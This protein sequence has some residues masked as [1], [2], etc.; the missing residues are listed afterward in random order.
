MVSFPQTALP[1]LI[2]AEVVPSLTT[3]FLY[4]K[5]IIDYAVY[6]VLQTDS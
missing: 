1:L 4:L 2:L 3:L 6:S 5:F